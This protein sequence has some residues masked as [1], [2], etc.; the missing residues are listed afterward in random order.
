MGVYA[1][2]VGSTTMSMTTLSGKGGMASPATFTRICVVRVEPSFQYDEE[3]GSSRMGNMNVTLVDVTWIMVLLAVPLF[4]MGFFSGA[5]WELNNSIRED[6]K[7][8]KLRG[9]E[10]SE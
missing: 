7:R 9:K 3:E 8:Y 5:W 4:A 1:G 6:R 10:T 2:S